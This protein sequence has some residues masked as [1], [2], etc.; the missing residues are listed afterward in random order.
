MGLTRG[1]SAAGTAEVSGEASGGEEARTVFLVVPALEQ[2]RGGGHLSRCLAFVRSLR[3]AGRDARLCVPAAAARAAPERVR[4]LDAGFDLSWIAVLGPGS[5]PPAGDGAPVIILDRFVTPR[6]EFEAWASLGPVIGIDE[7]GPCRGR[8]DFLLDILPGLPGRA[9]ANFTMPAL[10][11]LPLN[12]RPAF[13]A[14]AAAGRPR[15]LVSFG[16]EDAARLGA[17]T[18]K[19]LAGLGGRVSVD[20]PGA[21][22]GLRERLWEYDLLITHF[23]LGAF[24]ALHARVPALLVSPTAYHEKLARRAGFLSGGIGPAGAARAARLVFAPDL[25]QRC[26]EIAARFGLDS[27]SRV[28][29]GELLTR[30][31]SPRVCPCCGAASFTR[32]RLYRAGGDSGAAGARSYRVCPRCGIIAMLRLNPP[33]VE[34]GR[35]YFFGAY[36]KQ[37]GKTYLEDFP[38]LTAAARRRLA[39]LLALT[40]ATRGKRLLDIGCA[41]GPFLAAAREAGFSPEGI[42]PEAGAAGYVRDTLSIPCFRGFFPGPP[43]PPESFDAV[44]LWYVIEHFEAPGSVLQE[45]RRILKPGGALAFSTPSFRGVSGRVSLARFLERSPQDHWTVWSPRRARTLLKRLGFRVKRIV[46]TG[47]HPE[48]F[49][50]IGGLCKEG[51]P[52]RGSALLI[53]RLLRLGD[54][55]EIYAVKPAGRV[56]VRGA[57]RG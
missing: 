51:G 32:G 52:L 36:E 26:G 47:H 37:Y 31:R 6:L 15:V 18:V 3:E 42:E 10:L 45:I 1:K 19:A 43:L 33:P 14:P 27:E 13:A 53:S 46:I 34:Y 35:D 7:G 17:L 56:F 40:G 22:P 4:A 57:G 8:F 49:P 23:G 38:A 20:F 25:P 24:E 55:F 54:T 16:A 50:L 44:T 48:R 28:S 2:G 30:P 11:P 39:R 12:R 5:A 29:F 9:P 41:Y 21:V